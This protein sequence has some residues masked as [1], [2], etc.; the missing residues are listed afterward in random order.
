MAQ[1]FQE[2]LNKNK[3]TQVTREIQPP[4]AGSFN[5]FL[6]KRQETSR[7]I[8][9]VNRPV[10]PS[11]QSV[12]FTERKGIVQSVFSAPIN[13][14]KDL[15]RLLPS[16]KALKVT[17]QRAKNLA[18]QIKNSG[19]DD[20]RKQI[21]ANTL[22]GLPTYKD[23][24]PPRS[25]KQVIG[26]VLGTA[27]FAAPGTFGIKGATKVAT[28]ARGAAIGGAFGG[29]DALSEDADTGEFFKSVAVGTAIGAPV[30][31]GGALAVK[32]GSRVL[33]KA[34][35]IAKESFQKIL[36]KNPRVVMSIGA[37]LEKDFG[38]AGKEIA[39]R[40]LTADRAHVARAGKEL[41]AVTQAGLFNLDDEG[42]FKL[43]DLLEGRGKELLEPKVT[44][45]SKGIEGAGQSKTAE[46][47]VASQQKVFRGGE[48]LDIAQIGDRG[49][50]V[51]T[52]RKIAEQFAKPK[53]ELEDFVAPRLGREP[54]KVTV[55][56]SFISSS[57]KIA[58]KKDIPDDI[59]SAY[60]AAD[61]V[62]TPEKAEPIIGKWA[63]ENGFD[64]IDFRTLGKTSASEAEIKIL[65]PDVLKTKQQL[66]DIFNQTK[67]I[68]PSE[69]KLT[70][71]KPESITGLE[72]LSQQVTDS[73]NAIDSLRKAIGSE[74]Q[75]K[76]VQV[77][78]KR[79]VS[80][81]FFP[82]KDFFPH[83]TPTVER[84]QKGKIRD[85]VVANSVRTGK[86]ADE[87]EA[88]NVLDSYLE[89]VAQN[90]KGG[91]FWVNHLLETGQA[92]TK[93][94]AKGMTLRFFNRSRLERS[95]SLE[96]AREFDFPFYDPDP[97]R[98]IPAYILS[99]TKRLEE[100]PLFGEKFEKIDS[101][102]G[103]IRRKEGIDAGKEVSNLVKVAR[104]AIDASPKRE[105]IS[106]FL[107]TLQIPKLAFAQLSNAS[108]S[109]NTLLSADLKSLGK[110][111]AY[112]L[113][114]PGKRR[115]LQTGATLQSVL[116]QAHQASGVKGGFGEKFLKFTGFSA[117]EKANRVVAANTGFEYARSTFGK[118]L[119]KPNSPVFRGR[120]KE[121]GI[122]PDIALK[123]GTLAEDELLLAG[124]VMSEITQFRGR[125]I[126]LPSFF[127]SSPEGRV[128]TQYKSF[129]F[130]QAKFLKNKFKREIQAGNYK[131]VARDILILS[132]I[133]PMTGE[134]VAD[135]KSLATGSK[136]PTNL[137]DRYIE[138][139]FQVGGFGIVS[140]TLVSAKYGKL[141]EGVV[142]PTVSTVSQAV[143]RVVGATARQG[144]SEGDIKFLLQQTGFGRVI[145]NTAFPNN[146]KEQET[147]LKTLTESLLE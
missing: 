86:F 48:K 122:N 83:M 34:G 138:D 19:M 4:S 58:T 20:R 128:I 147:F 102:V 11:E 95:G 143:E 2:F 44:K 140:D 114:E 136:R 139:F 119:R 79:G 38:P 106:V 70:A 57:A 133:F 23:V 12:P 25:T 7:S 108:Q 65:N 61:P 15:A 99:S 91:E 53:K 43:V 130:Q 135:V 127:T 85:Q 64:A 17:E 98:V 54:K 97:R 32:A 113:T 120:L 126:D 137:L 93:D 72:T 40:F 29:A 37:R 46:E 14:G 88:A 129:A 73:F 10:A 8:Q 66:T 1:T 13:L 146:K 3:G 59:F 82:R 110:G 123:R 118:L 81:P 117:V 100:I 80:R 141:L 131:G 94:Q 56:E 5:D 107:R 71:L 21:L 89:F 101:L 74:A 87:N 49:L 42:A 63:K 51:T 112:S 69:R 121:L 144:V 26:D 9:P 28:L 142:G 62:L 39:E 116:R 18:E 76:G 27:L 90:G 16:A 45:L 50:P 132:T 30:Q 33:G 124:Q 75:R 22:E 24:F 96:H 134:V 52:D 111:I 115:A 109:L 68:L 125:A 105:K 55:E 31:L 41:D 145:A 103:Q 104:G 6:Q 35:A 92:K 60:K 47:F 84:L 36:E 77:K 78:L 67:K